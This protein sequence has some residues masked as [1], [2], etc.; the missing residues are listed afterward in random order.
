VSK[1]DGTWGEPDFVLGWL[2]LVLGKGRAEYYLRKAI[3]KDKRILFKISSNSICKQYPNIINKLKEMYAA[4]SN[5][6]E[7]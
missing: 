7:P 3:S 2:S 1:A 5:K 4:S 6:S